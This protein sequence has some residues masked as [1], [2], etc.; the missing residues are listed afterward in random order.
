[1]TVAI[2]LK[3]FDRRLQI[4]AGL[5]AEA[6]PVLFAVQFQRIVSDLGGGSV[7]DFLGFGLVAAVVAGALVVVGAR[8]PS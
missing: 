3:S 8:S 7:V 1:M 6:L 2:T 4:A 5:A